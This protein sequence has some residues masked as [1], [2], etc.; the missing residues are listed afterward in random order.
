ML[1]HHELC[2]GH[3]QSFPNPQCISPGEA[4]TAQD[5]RMAGSGHGEASLLWGGRQKSL[6]GQQVPGRGRNPSFGLCPG[7]SSSL[8]LWLQSQQS[9][10]EYL[11]SAPPGV[12]TAHATL[13]HPARASSSHL[14]IPGGCT[15][16][17]PSSATAAPL[18]P[19]GLLTHLWEP[20]ACPR[21]PVGGREPRGFMDYKKIINKVQRNSHLP[22][23][24]LRSH[25]KKA[26]AL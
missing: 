7:V 23:S 13:L 11:S 9:I 25:V 4:P 5:H 2:K 3:S 15:S 17:S 16:P 8:F 26:T 22:T 20:H 1:L 10:P 18:P 19:P 21:E 6:R 12:C 24:S 14:G